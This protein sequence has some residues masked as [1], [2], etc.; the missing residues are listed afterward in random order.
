[1]SDEVSNS[2]AEASEAK[3]PERKNWLEV[4]EAGTVLGIRFMVALCTLFGRRAAVAFLA[5]LAGYFVAFRKDVRRASRT[6][7][8]RLG[9]KPT[10][11][12]VYTHVRR[13]AEVATDRLFLLKGDFSHFQISYHG[14]EYLE[15]LKAQKRGAILLGAHLGSFEAMRMRADARTI[16][17]NVVGYFKNTARINSI[18]QRYNPNIVTRFIEVE[19]N[20]PSFIFKVRECIERGE[21]VAILGDR[22]GHGAKTEVQFLGGRAEMPTGAYAI[23]ATLKC[24]IYLT[25]G[26]YRAPNRYELY[27]EPFAE[28]VTL[29]RKTRKED[30]TAYAQKYADRLEHY[31]RLAPD[32]WFNF[33]DYWLDPLPE[34][35]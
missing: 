31:C 29:A 8:R 3:S 10:L 1:V 12:L 26:L 22:A 33:Y 28:N 35:K 23:A 34:E 7:F 9:M 25:F 19:P 5:V 2:K 11:S 32:N 17:I 6:Y 18:L 16:P 14:H 20:S 21:L 24:P 4:A 27:C 13:F 30:L 15:M